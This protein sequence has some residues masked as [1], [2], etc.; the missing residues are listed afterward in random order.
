MGMLRYMYALVYTVQ[1]YSPEHYFRKSEVMADDDTRSK[2][3]INGS[4]AREY[5]EQGAANKQ[6]ARD[7]D[8]VR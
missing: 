4:G 3:K 7:F 8:H 6:K 2:E 5:H 1:I